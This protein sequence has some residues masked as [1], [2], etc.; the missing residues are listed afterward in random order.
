MFLKVHCHSCLQLV[1]RNRKNGRSF[2]G[3]RRLST[4]HVSDV[5]TIIQKSTDSNSIF[6]A[7]KPIK[8]VGIFHIS[9]IVGQKI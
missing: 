4:K 7:G 3:H 5:E 9:Q 2:G 1:H 8:K 6:E